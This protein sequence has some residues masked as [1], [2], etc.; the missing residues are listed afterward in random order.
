M[1]QV[2]ALLTASS[3]PEPGL[4]AAGPML[5][6]HKMLSQLAKSQMPCQQIQSLTFRLVTPSYE[7]VCFHMPTCA[8]EKRQSK[9]LSAQPG[10]K[11]SHRLAHMVTLT[12]PLPSGRRA[13]NQVHGSQ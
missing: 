10:N 9:A 6:P 11:R 2:Q 3:G 1:G 7:G 12:Q 8:T 4:L 5:Y 13:S